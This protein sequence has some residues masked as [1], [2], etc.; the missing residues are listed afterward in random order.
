MKELTWRAALTKELTI[1]CL[2]YRPQPLPTPTHIFT[3]DIPPG[4]APSRGWA[5]LA[6]GYLHIEH[7]GGNHKSIL[8]EPHIR[9]LA[10][11]ITRALEKAEGPG[12]SISELPKAAVTLQAGPAGAVP[13]FCIPGAG[14]NVGCFIPLVQACGPRVP[15]VGLQARGYDGESVPHASVS[16]AARA[17]L[18]ELRAIAPHG[19]YRLLGHSFG[20]WI[21]FELGRLLE[22]AGEAVPPLVLVDCDAPKP[23]Q[24]WERLDVLTLL[25]ELLEMDHGCCLSLGRDTLSRLDEDSQVERLLAGMITAGVLP[26]RTPLCKL[27]AMLRVFTANVRAGYEPLTPY[28]GPVLLLNAHAVTAAS[29]TGRPIMPLAEKVERWRRHSPG[30][31]AHMLEGNH[32]SV[33]KQ[34]HVS[35][36]AAL[37]SNAW[38][39]NGS[40]QT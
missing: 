32:M 1:A 15:I 2:T 35:Q 11:A 23:A 12:G 30:L 36:L 24:P 37:L 14:A 7:I 31:E 19:P 5:P 16:A 21:A 34:P 29:A 38:S 25:I 26:Q 10:A 33:L 3:A 17:L 28:G 8:E 4:N 20:G 6:G 9:K 22:L 39:L 27:Q 13:L 40:A 18:P